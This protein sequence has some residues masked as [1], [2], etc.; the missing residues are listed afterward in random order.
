MPKKHNLSQW[1]DL[2][3]FYKSK[4][5]PKLAKQLKVTRVDQYKAFYYANGIL[6]PMRNFINKPIDTTSGKRSVELNTAVGGV[7]TSEHRWRNYDCCSDIYIIGGSRMD[8][9]RA[10]EFIMRELRHAVSEVI[11]YFYRNMQIKHFHIGMANGKKRGEFM[12]KHE[13]K[14]NYEKF[15]GE[16][17]K[18]PKKDV[19]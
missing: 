19:S 15:P 1:F 14:P 5:H 13:D 9:F 4:N 18:L 7:E 2:E 16:W 8:Y 6:D 11:L 12:I 17:P 3:D 10:Y